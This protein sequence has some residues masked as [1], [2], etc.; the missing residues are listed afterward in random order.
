MS[1]GIIQ[2]QA[3]NIKRLQAVSITPDGN[4]INIGGRNGQGKT[5]LL[6]S[7]EMALSGGRSIPGKP[8]RN[9]QENARIVVQ[10]DGYTITRTFT[11]KGSYLK[12]TN[13]DGAKFT[14]GQQVLDGIVG[15][16]SFDPLAFTKMDQKKQAETLLELL[17]IDT[18]KIDEEHSKLYDERT[19]MNREG[20]RYNDICNGEEPEF[21]I[22]KPE[23]SVGELLVQLKDAQEHNNTRREAQEDLDRAQNLVRQAELKIESLKEELRKAELELEDR[24]GYLDEAGDQW[25]AIGGEADTGTIEQEIKQLEETNARIRK[26]NHLHE[27]GRLAAK[28]I[29]RSTILSGELKKLMEKKRE[30]LTKAEYPIEGL[31]IDVDGVVMFNGI[32]F[33]QASAAEQIRVSMAVALAMNP[34]L[35]IVLIRD[36]SLLD[37]DSLE[38]IRVMA[39]ERDAQVWTERVGEGDECQVI[40]E[41]GMVK[42]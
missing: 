8:I 33:D 16:L 39:A 29:S 35:R 1:H 24:R 20:K 15:K 6:D 4:F 10:I 2:L 14:N 27:M 40:I 7:I 13:T 3:E 5:S 22:I 32:P 21:P 38:L 18:S 30:L 25:E 42:A 12:V 37:A 28:H 31:G 19:E 34:Q 11:E 17:N 26:S 41:D 23:Q 9:G 36:A